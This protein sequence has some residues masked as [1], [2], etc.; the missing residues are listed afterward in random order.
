MVSQLRHYQIG[1]GRM[2]SNI[3]GRGLFASDS[4]Q[5]VYHLILYTIYLRAT[6]IH[7]P[8]FTWERFTGSKKFISL[9]NRALMPDRA[10]LKH[11]TS[12]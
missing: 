12:D 3:T 1:I 11:G 7:P 9:H 5:R 4:G 8:T 2:R 10:P 6:P